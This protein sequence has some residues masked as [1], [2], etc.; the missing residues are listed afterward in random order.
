MPTRSETNIHLIPVPTQ[1]ASE[2]ICG[3]ISELIMSGELKPGDRL[4]SERNMMDMLKRSRPTIR[5][6]LRMLEQRGLIRTIPGSGGAE[7]M[8]P[9]S[10][11]VEEPLENMITLNQISPSE[12][13]EFRELIEIAAVRWAATRHTAEDL[14]AI[15]DLLNQTES[16]TNDFGELVKL[17]IAFHQAVAEAGHNRLSALVDRVVHQMVL[18]ILKT[19]Y[20]K[21]NNDEKQEMMSTILKS[22]KVI[23]EA[24]KSGDPD[25]AAQKTKTHISRFEKDLTR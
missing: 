17:D 16:K 19:A 1:K 14:Q 18:N 21:K 8:S 12:L 24:I 6:A 7:V 10:Q 3:Q 23:F 20:E 11:S 13:V 5:E 4:P 25:L 22:H 2:A 15:S 9:S